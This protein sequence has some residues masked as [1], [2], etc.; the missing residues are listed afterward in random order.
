VS[1]EHALVGNARVIAERWSAHLSMLFTEL[2]ALGRPAAA[3]AA[4]FS[5]VETW[6]PGEL[7]DGWAAA[8]AD[9]RVAVALVNADAGAIPAG[10]R[11]FLNVPS[12]RE[13]ELE[14][15]NAALT[16]AERVGCPRVNVLVG[17]LT[18]GLSEV[19]QRAA[20]VDALR[21]AATSA[22]A[23]GRTIVVEPI[24][25]RDVPGYLVPT[26]AEARR[27]IEA[28]GSGHVRL[29]YDAYHAARSGA[30][31]VREAPRFIDI[32]DHVQYADC[33]GRGAPGTGGIDIHR[34]VDALLEAG[35]AGSIGLEY[36]ARGD[37]AGSL[38]FLR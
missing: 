27:L 4:G 10:E 20:V 8:V 32:V 15:I 22:A 25:T 23:H 9:A 18:P 19:K 36:D 16:L 26:A 6:W 13:R 33:P 31:P 7:A 34:F 12:L 29:L 2:P 38:A 30:D 37:T 24:N 28:V 11:G 14:R 17:R 3:R 5:V 1:A 35:Y 21:E